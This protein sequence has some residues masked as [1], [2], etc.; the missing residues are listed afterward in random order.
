MVPQSERSRGT[1]GWKSELIDDFF[2]L[3]IVWNSL[4]SSSLGDSL[5]EPINLELSA[6]DLRNFNVSDSFLFPELLKL[7]D[8]NFFFVP[9]VYHK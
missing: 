5:V 1:S 6:A 4:G 9:V 8:K 3:L 2:P 7:T